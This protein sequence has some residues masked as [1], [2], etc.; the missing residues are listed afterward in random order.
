MR[1]GVSAKTYHSY[2]YGPN[3]FGM[4]DLATQAVRT[5]DPRTNRGIAVYTSPVNT[6][7]LPDPLGQLGFVSCKVAFAG[8][9]FDPNQV[10]KVITAAST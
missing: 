10:M 5:I 9:V 3:G 7:S 8:V 4:L 2:A 6:P 1:V